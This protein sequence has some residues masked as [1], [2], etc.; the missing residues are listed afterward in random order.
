M[1][2][3]KKM[4]RV[5][6][7]SLI[8]AGLLSLYGIHWGWFEPWNPDQMAFQPLF[9]KGKL[10]G[11]PG[12]FL[13]PPFHTY[14]NYFLSVLPVTILGKIL[15]LPP[16]LLSS[17]QLIWSR[18]LTVFLFLFSLII[19]FNITHKLFGKLEAQ[20]VTLLTATSAGFIT[21]NHFLTADIPVTFWMLLSLHFSFDILTKKQHRVSQQ[22]YL[23]SGFFAGIATATKYNGVVIGI[24]LIMVHIL[25]YPSPKIKRIIADKKIYLGLGMIG[26]G[27]LAGNP[28]ALLDYSNFIQDFMYN[29]IVTPAY[30]GQT[31]HSYFNFLDGI[32]EV[33]GD[34]YLLIVLIS[35]GGILGS[36][37]MKEKEFD[38]IPQ[39]G[40]II[41]LT[42][43]F[44]YYYKFGGFPRL[45][46]RFVLPMI[47][48]L[49]ILSGYFWNQIKKIKNF[50]R[51]WLFLL[52]ILLSYNLICSL[53]VGKRFT[54][55]PRMI[56][57][58]WA[59]QHFTQGK[60]I[61]STSYN[62]TW[63]KIPGVKLKEV[64]MPIITGRRKLFKNLFADNPWVMNQLKRRP[65][66][67][68]NWYTKT[69]LLSRK[70]DYI[71]INSLYYQRFLEGEILG[72]LYP[73]IK[74]YFSDLLEEKF[75]YKIVF[76]SQ[77]PVY[78]FW[79]YPTTIDFLDNRITIL[80]PTQD[81]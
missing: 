73:S 10:P 80:S 46:T 12:G 60:L 6:L 77:S 68:E 28:F 27:F 11:N 13:K 48:W 39:K 58:Q 69:A 14:F 35:L 4:D 62:P 81:E 3:V 33:I 9:I 29:Y 18:L 42:L 71:A 38:V 34:P 78:P 72:N 45:E 61:E 64:K 65:E 32:R 47:P 40:M 24:A 36:Y 17:I 74:K 59:P 52:M 15:N 57:Q 63:N 53:W 23:W 51:I 56:A 21:F 20:S 8:L 54:E 66:D 49:L 5:L 67:Q 30:E 70:P 25:R 1:L 55:D 31:G 76:D 41:C 7:I 44:I 79:I 2:I 26:V 75:P 37:L 19:I 22:D 16:H 43:S 50:Q